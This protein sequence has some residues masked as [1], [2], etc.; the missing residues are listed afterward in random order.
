M[1]LRPDHANVMFDG[2]MRTTDPED[3]EVG[4]LIAVKPGERVPLDARVVEGNS[5]ID[6]SALTGESI[7]KEI[8]PGDTLLSGSINL[9]GMLIAEVTSRFEESTV[10]KILEMVENSLSRKAQSERFITR[11]A[12]FYTPVVVALAAS[13]SLSRHFVS[14]QEFSDWIYRALVFCNIPPVCTCDFGAPRFLAA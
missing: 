5:M 3:V 11:F 12:R 1:E 10:S 8:E 4:Q 9:N 14:G 7:P 2:E 13:I 6:T